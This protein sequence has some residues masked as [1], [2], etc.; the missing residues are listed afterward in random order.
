MVRLFVAE[1]P[2][3]AR[4]LARVLGAQDRRRPGVLRGDGVWV[5]WCVGHLVE[6]CEPGAYKDS[7]RAWRIGELPMLPAPFA[8]QPRPGSL[9]QYEVVR[10]AMRHREV[11]SVVNAC[12]AGR[13]GELIFAYVYQLADCSKK[14]ERLWLSALTDLAIRQALASLRPGEAYASLAAA[15][16]C[17]AEADWLVG[18]NATRALTLQQGRQALCSVGRVQTPTL[19]LLT[20]REAAIEAFVPEPY[21]QLTAGFL[22]QLADQAEPVVYQGLYQYADPGAAGAAG[23][24]NNQASAP[25]NPAR[26][27]DK[28]F[29]EAVRSAVLQQPAKIT[30]VSERLQRLQAPLFF[31]LT[32][33]QR[34]AN[35]LFKLSASATLT[36]LQALYERHKVLTYPRTDAAVLASS[37]RPEADR[38]LQACQSIAPY[39][40]HVELARRGGTA[41]FPK[42]LFNDAG[43]GDHHAIVPTGR[44]CP[45]NLSPTEQKVYDMVLRRFVAAFLPDVQMALSSLTTTVKVPAEGRAP[46][47]PAACR[48]IS[49]GRLCR[50]I[51]WHAVEP[52]PAHGSG[53]RL[54]PA[55]RQGQEVM[56]Q[57]A[58]V[59]DHRTQP[60]PRYSDAS[61]LGAMESAGS[62]LTDLQLRRAMRDSGLGTP[63]TRAQIIDT[64]IGRAYVQR[65]ANQ[66]VP[67]SAGR[68]L[69]AAL[70]G[71]PLVQAELTAQWEAGLAQVARGE[72][73]R[74][75][76]MQQVRQLTTEVVQQICAGPRPAGGASPADR[77][78]STHAPGRIGDSA[79]SPLDTR[80]RQ[81]P[82]AAA[83][84]CPLCGRGSLLRG[85]SAW[86]CARWRAGCRFTLEFT[87]FGRA[88]TEQDLHFLLKKG[89]TAPFV[90]E[91]GGAPQQLFL[92]L[93]RQPALRRDRAQA[94]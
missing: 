91:E 65:E 10:A 85:R 64:L 84:T 94:D 67:T 38:I 3:V 40:P 92:D 43:I 14:V 19:A 42:R 45:A 16:R 28:A 21:W 59:T 36:A 61:L 39:G 68:S 77:P 2:S 58:T 4:D 76:F 56:T 35:R 49:R 80:W 20:E 22:A 5:T 62:K 70:P 54:L 86:G 75:R 88:L 25:A 51:G 66:L 7:W 29:V 37:M 18:I 72:L 24:A 73:L 47:V 71:S 1:K 33:A 82:P 60:P 17:R 32:A 83:Y 52:P 53:D 48:F 30:G 23:A 27:P 41:A 50:E 79:S 8:L 46:T 6:L 87:S 9:D 31:D 13:E 55:V 34:Q 57:K 89:C 44:A 74:D 15:A 78:P 26:C 81:P 63:A 69:V 90:P 11:R 12:D 93:A